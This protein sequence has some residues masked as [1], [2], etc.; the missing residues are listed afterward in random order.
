MNMTEVARFLLGLRAAGW[1]EK[2]IND[3]KL[4]LVNGKIGEI[5]H[6]TKWKCIKVYSNQGITTPRLYTFV[7]AIEFNFAADQARCAVMRQYAC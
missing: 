3:F 1:T 4:R 6:F 7:S 2:E 5:E